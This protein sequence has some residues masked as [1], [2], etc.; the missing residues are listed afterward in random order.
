MSFSYLAYPQDEELTKWVRLNRPESK[1]NYRRFRDY[2]AR[3]NPE[4]K[5]RNA[6]EDFVLSRYSD[7]KKDTPC[8][9]LFLYRTRWELTK[10]VRLNCPESIANNGQFRDYAARRNPEG[11]SRNA[12]EDFV[13]SRYSDKKRNHPLGCLFLIWHIRKMKNSRSEFD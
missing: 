6:S 2:A 13:L 8:G 1:A 12:S 7:K 5:S 10:W 11:K 3:R 4:G 9:C